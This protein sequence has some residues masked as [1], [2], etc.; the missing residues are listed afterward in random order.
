MKKN[1]VLMPWIER[2]Q[3]IGNSGIGESNRTRGYKYGMESWKNGVRKIT[4]NFF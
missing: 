4:L 3:S 2:K 1:V